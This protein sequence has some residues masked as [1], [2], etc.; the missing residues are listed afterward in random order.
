MRIM[1]KP[2]GTEILL[3]VQEKKNL[4]RV[5][6]FLESLARHDGGKEE[7]AAFE[8]IKPVAAKWAPEEKATK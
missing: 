1:A 4:R 7:V 5:A 2:K 6:Q 8:A 3:D